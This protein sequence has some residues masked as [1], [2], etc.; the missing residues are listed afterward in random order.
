MRFFPFCKYIVSLFFGVYRF[1]V[2]KA[3]KVGHIIRKTPKMMCPTRLYF[4]DIRKFGFVYITQ[5]KTY[6]LASSTATAAATVIPTMGLLP[7]PV[8]VVP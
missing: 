2:W 4:F 8:G 6:L 5:I 7:F 3:K 1:D